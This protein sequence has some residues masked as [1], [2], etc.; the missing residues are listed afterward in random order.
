MCDNY[1]ISRFS[2]IFLELREMRER[3]NIDIGIF[4]AFLAMSENLS[5]K[6][7]NARKYREMQEMREISH[8]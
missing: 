2:H 5:H 4:I 8:I 7:R 6:M 1:R 3:S